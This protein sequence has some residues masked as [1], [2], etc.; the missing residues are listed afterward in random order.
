MLRVWKRGST[1]LVWGTE[2]ADIVGES[3][4]WCDFIGN[5]KDRGV[6]PFLKAANSRF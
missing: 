2:W 4:K 5:G 6:I 3:R 1:G